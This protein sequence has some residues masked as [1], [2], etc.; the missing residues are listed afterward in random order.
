[1]PE[2]LGSGQFAAILA[3]VSARRTGSDLQLLVLLDLLCDETRRAGLPLQQRADAERCVLDFKYW[4]DEPGSDNMCYWSEA[5][6]LVFSACSYLAGS[7]FPDAVFTNSGR[8]GTE[9]RQLGEARLRAWLGLRFRL[10]MFEWLSGPTY[11]AV[12]AALKVLHEHAEPELATRVAMVLDLV[13][14][15]VVMHSFEGDFAAAGAHAVDDARIAAAVA[16]AADLPPPAETDL[17]ARI[18]CRADKYRPPEVLQKI[19]YDE[20]THSIFSTFSMDAGDIVREIDPAVSPVDACLLAWQLGAFATPAT[21]RYSLRGYRHW[22][23]AG[24]RSLARLKQMSRPT[25]RLRYRVED[26]REV[27]ARAR[28]ASFRTRHYQLSSV[29][30]YRVG[31]LT[32]ARPWRAVLPGGIR[33]TGIQPAGMTGKT[34]SGF[35]PAVGQSEHVLLALYDTHR[36]RGLR[37]ESKVVLPLADCDEVRLGRTWAAAQVRGSFIGLLS[38]TPMELVARDELL[39]RGPV[40]GWAVVM[41]DRSQ[42]TSLGVFAGL[43]KRSRLVLDDGRLHLR[44]AES[45]RYVLDRDGGLKGPAGRVSHPVGRYRNPWVKPFLPPTEVE[46]TADPHWLRLDWQTGVREFG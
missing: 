30:G 20:Q 38:V 23:L 2:A 45:G 37:P 10:G 3:F 22:R 39:Q 28:V 5:D 36:G 40:T 9:Q 35:M 4:L 13:L 42:S 43:L 8:T 32:T 27:L 15:D 41:G 46:V 16:L 12:L 33:V 19:A 44:L 11:V 25:K 7:L 18:I 6:H 21:L 24:N 29:Q 1:M 26:D 34:D 17:V 31:E 14:L